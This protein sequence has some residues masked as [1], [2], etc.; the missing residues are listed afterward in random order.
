MP[1]ETIA[2]IRT[3]A[4]TITVNEKIADNGNSGIAIVVNT[5]DI[6]CVLKCVSYQT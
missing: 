6:S 5:T 4:A 2:T 1:L 3:E